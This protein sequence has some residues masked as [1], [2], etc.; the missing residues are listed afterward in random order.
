MKTFLVPFFEPVLLSSLGSTR[1][2]KVAR[3]KSPTGHLV[4]KVFILHDQTLDLA[5]YRERLVEIKRLLEGC[6]N[7]MPFSR[8]IVR[9]ND[10][11][12]ICALPQ[13]LCLF[14]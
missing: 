11:F 4:V 9:P 7:C 5:K 6:I 3:A 8:V 13:P 2:F 1:F 12:L 10:I 14:G